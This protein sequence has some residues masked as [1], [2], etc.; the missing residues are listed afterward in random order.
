MST[1]RSL[2]IG[3]LPIGD[4]TGTR[5]ASAMSAIRVLHA[6]TA[7]PSIRIPHEP[8]IIIRQ[9]F[10]YASVPSTLS[11]IRSST[12]SSVAHSGAS[13]SYSTRRRSP[14][15]PSYRQI[16]SATSISVSVLPLHGLP[17]RNR[18][19]LPLQPRRPVRVKVDERVLH[20]VLV[21]ALR[22][23]VGTRVGAAA[24]LA[25]EAGDDH[26][27][28]EVEQE[29]ELERLR[30]VAVEQVALVVQDDALV[31]LTQLLDELA[32]PDHLLLAPEHAEVLVHRL[33]QLVAD[34]PRPLALVAVEQRLQLALGIRHRALRDLHGRVRERPLGRV[35]ARPLAER[36]RLHER[37]AAQPVG[38][39]DGDARDL[40]V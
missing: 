11:L 30:Q 6:S 20:V 39:V 27:A 13:T 38:A 8:Q 40:A 14:V 2:T 24:L 17:F 36:D 29:A 31:A 3:R 33:R 34:R 18:N 35:P 32:L 28:R 22:V 12:S 9:L 4:T 25:G 7:A 15:S 16:L 26:A 23:V 37:V 10:R 19:R 21:V 5:P 1:T